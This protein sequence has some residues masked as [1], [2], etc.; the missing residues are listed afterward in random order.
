MSTGF[1]RVGLPGRSIRIVCVTLM[2]PISWCRV[3]VLV[4]GRPVVVIWVIVPDV[5]VDVQRR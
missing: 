5:L 4:R 3:V 2:L 1:A